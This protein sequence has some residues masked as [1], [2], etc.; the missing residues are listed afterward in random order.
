MSEVM[1]GG[2]G[3]SGGKLITEYI[4]FNHNWTVPNNVKNNEFS[5]RIFGGGG[6]SY[7]AG[8]GSGW[9]NNDTK[10]L[11]P[12]SVVY[13]SI[14][15]GGS[16]IIGSS[17]GTSSFG[18][19]LS[20]NGASGASGGAGGNNG[21]T[22]YQF[23]G[24]FGGYWD[25]LPGGVWGGGG[26]CFKNNGGS[27]GTYG[28]GGC[29]GLSHNGKRAGN[30]GTY[31]GGGGGSRYD[32]IGVSGWS[33]GGTGGTYGGNGCWFYSTKVAFSSIDTSASW[34]HK[35]TN[36]INTSTWTNVTKDDLTGEYFRGKGL[37]NSTNHGGGGGGYGGNGG[38]AYV[39]KGSDSNYSIY[40]GG[41][42]G[43]GSNG[44]SAL[45]DSYGQTGGG[46]GGYG[47]DGGGGGGG[48]GYGKVSIGNRG[49][50]GY[51]CPGGGKRGTEGGGGFGI[52]RNG[53]LEATFA[54]GGQRGNSSNGEPGICVIQ[55]YI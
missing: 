7:S 9:M 1:I 2:S 38:R 21:G 6:W 24:G 12:A 23:G 4:T 19:Y 34:Y 46:G 43:Y 10:T 36:G 8:G 13:I 55:Y 27:G 32:Y 28:G 45:Y 33:I 16:N 44:G 31:G 25:G 48:G 35:A 29:G 18:T 50:G 20:A 17:G 40:G 41:G 5:I 51:Y 22:G 39:D 49:G 3:S 26:G 14:G 37:G 30:G 42:G 15:Q 54:S 52:W 53:I 47:G 11:T